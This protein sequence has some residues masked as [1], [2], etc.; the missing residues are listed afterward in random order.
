MEG[1]DQQGYDSGM[2]VGT[3]ALKAAAPDRQ[4]AATCDTHPAP[5]ACG[6]GPSTSIQVACKSLSVC[7]QP[8]ERRGLA[9]PG[10]GGARPIDVPPSSFMNT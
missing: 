4:E 6:L 5:A 7:S 9:V 3:M 1:A 8:W 10:K 2:P